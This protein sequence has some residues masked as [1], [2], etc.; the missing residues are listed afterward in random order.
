MFPSF[1]DLTVK[2]FYKNTTG[3]PVGERVSLGE[4]MELFAIERL[5]K[6]KEMY[7]N[8]RAMNERQ[9]AQRQNDDKALSS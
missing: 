8:F 3:T 2:T 5:A 4:A 6:D 7:W 9:I 1:G